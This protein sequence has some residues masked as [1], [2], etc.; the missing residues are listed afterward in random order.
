MSTNLSDAGPW[1]YSALGA[2]CRKYKEMEEALQKENGAPTDAGIKELLKGEEPEE[3]KEIFDP[4][5]KRAVE[6]MKAIKVYKKASRV[7]EAKK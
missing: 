3:V 7:V 4:Q 5:L 6:V 1:L 2:L